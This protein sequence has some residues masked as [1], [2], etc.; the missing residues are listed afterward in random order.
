M[1]MKYGLSGHRAAVD[2]DVEPLNGIISFHD[3]G[4]RRAQEFVDRVAF[5]IVQVEE[6][7]YMPFG[8]DESV[9]IGHRIGT[10]SPPLDLSRC[11]WKDA[12]PYINT[13]RMLEGEW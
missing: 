4:P 7:R 9:E 5:G 12:A 2:A 3:L 10:Q 6:I 1:A 8:N 11:R 13:H